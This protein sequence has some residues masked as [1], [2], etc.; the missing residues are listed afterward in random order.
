VEDA[1]RLLDLSPELLLEAAKGPRVR[2]ELEDAG[3]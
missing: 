2:R 3:E 1:G